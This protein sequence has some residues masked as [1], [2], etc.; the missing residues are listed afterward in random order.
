[1]IGPSATKSGRPCEVMPVSSLSWCRT[2]HPDPPQPDLL[3]SR[4]GAG[5]SAFSVL[6]SQAPEL[7][8]PRSAQSKS[9]WLMW[10]HACDVTILCRH[11]STNLI[12]SPFR[13]TYSTCGTSS[14]T[15]RGNWCWR[16]STRRPA[17]SPSAFTAGA[18]TRRPR[19]RPRGQHS[20]LR[21]SPP[22][23]LWAVHVW[24]FGPRHSRPFSHRCK[25]DP[26]QTCHEHN[27]LPPP[28][29]RVVHFG[30]F[31]SATSTE[32]FFTPVRVL[33]LAADVSLSPPDYRC[34]RLDIWSVQPM[35]Q[36]LS[37]HCGFGPCG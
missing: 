15:G 20:A 30:H 18:N 32:A 17:T 16:S 29:L 2:P 27:V 7:Q 4:D 9:A 23:H 1:M 22:P 12:C 14:R 6:V 26:K 28:P 34:S 37:H 31:D 33:G 35:R 3:L 36:G 24:K 25:E 13:C 19:N 11:Q 5:R 8:R 21:P 10:N